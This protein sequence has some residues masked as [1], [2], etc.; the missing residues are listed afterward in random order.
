MNLSPQ[1]KPIKVGD[2]IILFGLLD[3]TEL[4]AVFK[5]TQISQEGGEAVF[6]EI[7]D[8]PKKFYPA[9]INKKYAGITT[10]FKNN[11]VCDVID[12]F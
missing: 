10:T 5:V 2:Y 7:K 1:G 9:D 3:D 4:L 8:N 11:E 12:R 6:I